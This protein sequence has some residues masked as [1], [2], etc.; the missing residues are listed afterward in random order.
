MRDGVLLSTDVLHRPGAAAAPTILVRTPYLKR[1][2]L[3]AE[4]GLYSRWLDDG[5]VLVLQNERG[6]GWSGGVHR[7]LAGATTDGLDTLSWIER[8]PW[9][10]GRVG[11]YG[12]SSGAEPQLALST[13][14]HRAL[15]AMI[16]ESPAAGIG[17]IPGVTSQGG[18]YR[19]GIPQLVPWVRWYSQYSHRYRPLM[20]ADM[21]LAERGRIAEFFDPHIPGHQVERMHDDR[22]GSAIHTLPSARIAER[23]GVPG[24]EL[25]HQMRLSPGDPW[26][27]TI[28]FLNAPAKPRVPALYVS[29]WYDFG[30]EDLIALFAHV[31]DV[32]DQ[33]LIVSATPHCRMQ[34]A[35]A[36]TV[37]GNRNVGDPRLDY[38]ELYTNW[39]RRWL[40]ADGAALKADALPRVQA[41]EVGSNRWRSG[42]Q[43]PIEPVKTERL[44]LSAVQS[45]ASEFGDGRL[46]ASPPAVS[47]SEAIL[48]DPERPVP[49]LG[50]GCC[51]ADVIQDQR[52][53]ATRRDVLV[54][55]SEPLSE[56]LLLSGP[57]EALLHVSHDRPDGDIFLTVSQVLANGTSHN[58]GVSALRLRYRDSV[59]SPARMKPGVVYPVRLTGIVTNTRLGKGDR[60]RIQITGTNFPNFERNLHHGDVNADQAKPLVGRLTVHEGLDMASHLLITVGTE[61]RA[62][63]DSGLTS[64]AVARIEPSNP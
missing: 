47:R 35:T 31:S 60:L 33:H 36:D 28:D 5:F 29:T 52:K 9:S 17:T 64:E 26:W 13:V 63:A 22:P 62:G 1:R 12:C 16:A 32:P 37:V 53:A 55:T 54:Y 56:P 48:V 23:L 61:R 14:G 4:A 18:F 30:I 3:L 46:L 2:N 42:A 15:K 51:G 41:Y 40:K 10:N 24:S 39:F 57:I 19:G 59:S 7:F 25:A 44:Y 58:L 50:G 6:S 21:P 8:Q 20:P 49:S 11:L 45:A 38:A 43:W 34:A 27:K